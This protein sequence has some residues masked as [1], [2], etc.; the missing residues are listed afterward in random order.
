MDCD[1]TPD[2]YVVDPNSGKEV[3]L[4]ISLAHPW[5]LD[6]LPKVALE[7]GTAATRREML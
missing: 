1:S 5:A 6:A 2:I 7:D 3:E 4:D